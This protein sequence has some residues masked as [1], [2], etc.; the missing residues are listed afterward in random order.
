MKFAAS[1]V[2][3]EP[4][5]IPTQLGFAGGYQLVGLGKSY[6]QVLVDIR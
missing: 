3:V 6:I 4:F 1:L 5:V 2:P